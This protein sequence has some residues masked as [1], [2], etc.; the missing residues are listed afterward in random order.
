MKWHSKILKVHISR[1]RNWRRAT[2]VRFCHTPTQRKKTTA[3]LKVRGRHLKLKFKRRRC[4][5]PCWRTKISQKKKRR[6]TWKIL[7]ERSTFRTSQERVRLCRIANKNLP[8][9]ALT[10]RGPRIF[11]H[12]D[13]FRGRRTQKKRLS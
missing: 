3:P 1:R 10:M 7:L 6:R 4:P 12:L 11:L 8:T 2:R 13:L 9:R 5:L